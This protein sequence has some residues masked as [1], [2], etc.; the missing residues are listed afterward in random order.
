MM[1]RAIY[2]N[3]VFRPIE[4]VNLPEQ[5]RVLVMPGT[6]DDLTPQKVT[7][8]AGLEALRGSLHSWPDDPVEGQ[9]RLRDGCA[10]RNGR[11]HP[12]GY[13]RRHPVPTGA[14]RYFSR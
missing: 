7:T 3:G 5:S 14:G 8:I 10:T 1:I 6:A 11:E 13:E 12:A 4:P 9:R 2:E